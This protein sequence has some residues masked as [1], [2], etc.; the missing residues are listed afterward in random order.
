MPN[1]HAAIK[2]LRKNH[3]HAEQNAR[4]KTNVKAL[5]KQLKSLV[6]DG[7]KD[8]A[9]PVAMKLQQAAAKASKTHVFHQNKS[10]RIAS[11][12]AKLVNTLK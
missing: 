1:K 7:K 9:K 2:D 4:V 12:A 11:A 5:Q 6:K 3:K 10:S 8:E